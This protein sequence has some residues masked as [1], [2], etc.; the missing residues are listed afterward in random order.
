MIEKIP[1]DS[2]FW[3]ELDP[4]S[5]PAVREILAEFIE[6]P[7]TDSDLFFSL[8]ER[9]CESNTLY[10]PFYLAF[11]YLAEAAAGKPPEEALELWTWIGAWFA[12]GEEGYREQIPDEVTAVYR[13]A[14]TEAE[15]AFFDFLFQ[16]DFS[17]VSEDLHYLLA[18]PFGLINS[19]FVKAAALF[20][21]EIELE[22]ACPNGHI[23]LYQ[24]NKKGVFNSKKEKA[25]DSQTLYGHILESIAQLPSRPNNQWLDNHRL[26]NHRLNNHWLELLEKRAAK[27]DSEE[28]CTAY[29][30]CEKG[31]DENTP[32]SIAV[33]LYAYLLRQL[34][35]NKEDILFGELCLKMTGQARCPQCGAVFPLLDG[36]RQI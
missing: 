3:T 17:E 28:S 2:P 9:L 26:N 21:S 33:F 4:A 23:N 29:T 36:W 6:N 16:A 22:A 15:E 7:D 31:I 32:L 8:C 10:P 11:P 35:S 1:L 25:P 34:S 12:E 24:I 5:S 30:L 20:D 27:K 13:Q 18:V 14:Q 19:D